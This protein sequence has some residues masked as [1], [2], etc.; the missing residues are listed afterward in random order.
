MAAQAR[1][2][3]LTADIEAERRQHG[4]T[5]EQP[6]AVSTELMTVKARAEAQAGVELEQGEWLKRAQADLAAARGA[7]AKVREEAAE[8]R[9]QTEVLQAQRAQ[10]MQALKERQSG[11][12]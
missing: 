2:Q 7:A 4:A 9:G 6:N 10:L 1:E 8:L 5:R 12:A 11:P 3:R